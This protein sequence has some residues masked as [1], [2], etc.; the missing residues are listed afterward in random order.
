[1][2]LLG[3]MGHAIAQNLPPLGTR[4]DDSPAGLT[5]LLAVG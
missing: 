4:S 3:R 1:M 5:E 2:D